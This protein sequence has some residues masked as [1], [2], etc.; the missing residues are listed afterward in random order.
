VLAWAARNVGEGV[1]ELLAA[2]PIVAA[3][4]GG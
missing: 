2:Q 3:G 1:L 4:L